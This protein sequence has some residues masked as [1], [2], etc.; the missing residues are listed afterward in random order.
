MSEPSGEERVVEELEREIRGFPWWVLLVQGVTALI[1]GVLLFV[2]P[3]AATVG[4]VYFFGWYW[5]VTG[6]FTILSLLKDRTQW[7]WHLA[8]GLLS[9]IAGVYIIGSPMIGA[10][11]F[12]GVITILIGV[13]GVIIGAVDIGRA[14]RGGGW[15]IG[16]LGVLSFVIG[17][18]IALD[19]E[20]F[21]GALPWLWAV[22]ATAAGIASI[23]AA[24]RVR[25]GRLP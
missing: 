23:Y 10:E 22:L 16:A 4:L 6:A 14:Y 3:V 21:M 25:Q 1:V 13:N 15:G 12:V 11:I 7:G 20:R 2:A 19:F 9:V 8:S 5:L 17:L 18:A 24:F